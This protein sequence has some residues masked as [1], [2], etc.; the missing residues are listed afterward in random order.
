MNPAI[1]QIPE[2][3][4]TRTSPTTLREALA[5]IR[6]GRWATD[7]AKVRKAYAEAAEFD[8]DPKD[9]AAPFKRKLAG[10]LFSGTFSRRAADAL[11]QHSGLI[12]VDL[13]NLGDRV[14]ATKEQLASDP[15]L[16]AAF[17]SPT[18]TGLKAIF[19]CTPTTAAKHKAE[20][21]PAAQ[22]YILTHF[23]LEIDVACS[24]VSRICFASH[25]P[26]LFETESAEPL[27]AY[28][29]PQDFAPPPGINPSSGLELT[30]GDDYDQRGDFRGLL[31]KHGWSPVGK[32]G[33]RRPD[34]GDGISATF[35]HVPGRFYVFSSSTAFSPGHTYRPWHAYA[36]LEHGGDFVS[37]ARSLSQNGFGHQKARQQQNLDR[38]SPEPVPE[39]QLQI[40]RPL[41]SFALPPKSDPSTLIGRR[42][43]CRGDGV[44]LSSTS[45]MGKSTLSIYLAAHWALARAPF[46]AF[47][48]AKPITS[49]IFQSEDSEGDVAEMQLSTCHGMQLTP[50]DTTLVGERV[51]I[52]TDRVNRGP[53]F[54][55]AMKAQIALHKPDIVWI[56]PLLAFLG[57]DINDAEEAGNFLRGGLNGANEPATHAYILIHHTSK[58]PKE[59]SARKWNEVMYDMAGSADLTNWAR[60]VISLRP[61]DNHGEFNLV[62]AKRGLRACATERTE[63][64]HGIPQETPTMVI[65]IRHSTERFTP[66]GGEEMPMM[67]WE[68]CDRAVSDTVP[69]S[70]AGRKRKYEPS[71][72]AAIWPAKARPLGFRPLHRAAKDIKPAIGVSA[73]EA[74]LEDACDRGELVKDMSNPRAPVYYAA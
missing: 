29:P 22:Q 67:Y 68:K 8:T 25:D 56:N 7:I 18:G 10:F 37:A 33:W 21:F 45:G 52:V 9:A 55:K 51:K 30:P 73:F 24:D 69:Q 59:K 49:L 57:A 58:P 31:L 74:V 16:L 11:T 19:R 48:P 1:S 64:K 12:C 39:P 44:I 3:T 71:D 36:I 43:I 42:Y 17:T 27:P 60:A 13:D 4:A 34:K 20:V 6:D 63:G 5:G 72:F 38:L 28:Q 53:A 47:P 40:A 15:H 32:H 26:E 61:G 54:I 70:P 41:T 65:P 14:A 50:E 66:Q 35:D 62:L 23:G 2:A 46:G